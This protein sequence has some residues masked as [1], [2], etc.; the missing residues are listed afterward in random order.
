MNNAA[1]ACTA[2]K[3]GP[4]G[5]GFLYLFFHLGDEQRRKNSYHAAV[6]SKGPGDKPKQNVAEGSDAIFEQFGSIFTD[7]F[8]GA[9]GASQNGA[10]R[11]M[12]LPI[13]LEEA[14]LGASKLVKAVHGVRCAR[15]KGDGGEPDGTT[16][17]C[18]VCEGKGLQAKPGGETSICERCRGKK[19]IALFPCAVCQGKKLVMRERELTVK[20]PGGVSEGQI[21]RLAGQGD[22]ATGKG[23]A[24]HLLLEIVVAPHPRFRR[25]GADLL[26][27][28]R[29]D[30]QLAET[31]GSATVPVIGGSRK[32]KVPRNCEEGTVVRLRGQGALRLGAEL[33]SVSPDLATGTDPYRSVDAS[34]FRGDLIVTFVVYT[35]EELDERPLKRRGLGGRWEWGLLVAL[36]GA[37]LAALAANR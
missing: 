26:V 10:D 27:N 14:A 34:A 37:V 4:R 32:I 22:E 8:G 25:Q 9:G 7:F 31:G 35:D 20:V 17:A 11:R 5:V 19:T 28:V 24:G 29:I 33:P 23:T 13:S 21:L 3:D 1:A 16:H 12:A 30:Q 36:A 2:G 15:C 6:D 18:P